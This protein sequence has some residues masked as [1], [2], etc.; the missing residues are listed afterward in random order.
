[1]SCAI[2]WFRNDLRLADNPAL[3]QACDRA[4]RLL[5]VYC[6]PNPEAQTR[7]GFVRVGR[8]RQRFLRDALDALDAALRARGS[9]LIE[10]VGAPTEQLKRIAR[11]V[12]ASEIHCEQIAAP[13]EQATVES[14]RATDMSVC[15]RWQSALFEQLPFEL[16]QLPTQ[17]T[18]FRV[19]IESAG[20][21]PR[22]ALPP[23]Q[24]LPPLPVG[25]DDCAPSRPTASTTTCDHRSAFPYAQRDF[26]GASEA[27]L[28]HLKR[29]FNSDLPIRY[30]STRNQLIGIDYSTKFSPWLATGAVSARQVH[31]ALIEH[32]RDQ[33]RSDGS[34]WIWFE[35]LWR[36]YFRW[37]HRRH[38]ARLYHPNGLNPKADLPSHD[39]TRFERWC[40]GECGHPLVDAGMRELAATGYLSNRMRQIVASY[41]IHELACDYRAGAAW[42]EAQLIDYDVYS[43]QGNWLYIAGR[44]TD[45]RGGRRFDPDWQA[46]QYDPDERYRALWGDR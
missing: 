22:A 42:F 3:L 41:L 19:A 17:F 29:Y 30:K 1:M 5:P 6:H 40:R 12:G 43:N 21:L 16:S 14:L 10:V 9:R 38:G 45:P 11:A 32:E 4:E 28:A 2:Y 44:G 7:W 26:C 25:I 33:G 20:D 31:A 8:H 18:R 36:E 13:E 34:Y 35:L 27:G 46:R 37:L 39:P 24:Q 23:A 15:E